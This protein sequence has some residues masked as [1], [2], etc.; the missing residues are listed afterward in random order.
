MMHLSRLRIKCQPITDSDTV[1]EV[2]V[3]RSRTDT[4]HTIVW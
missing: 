3:T 2:S 4:Y 1:T